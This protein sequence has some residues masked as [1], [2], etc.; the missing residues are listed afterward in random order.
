MTGRGP[1]LAVVGRDVEL[2]AALVLGF[3]LVLRLLLRVLVL[4]FPSLAI[5][6]ELSLAAVLVPRRLR[7]RVL[8]LLWFPSLAM[9]LELSLAAELLPRRFRFRVLVVVVAEVVSEVVLPLVLPVVLKVPREV[10]PVEVSVAAAAR[11]R[12][13]LRSRRG[14]S[15]GSGRVAGTKE[16]RTPSRPAMSHPAAG[17][18]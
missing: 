6:L 8:V 14:S 15:G 13:R 5:V 2:A 12:G 17:G 3:R 10:L 16:E 4:W 9:V 7:F 11:G 18:E 1:A